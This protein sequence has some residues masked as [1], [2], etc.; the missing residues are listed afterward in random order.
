MIGTVDVLLHLGAFTPKEGHQ[1]NAIKECNSNIIF[2]ENL[3]ALPF[4][5]LKKVI[6]VST[7]DVYESADLI[8]EATPT[9][10]TSLYGWSKL[11]CEQ[12]TSIFATD[13]FIT[14][15]ILRIG[16]VYGPGEEGYSKFLPKTIKNILISDTVELWGDGSEIHSF[17]YIDDVIEATLQSINLVDNVGP[18]NVV[19]GVPITISNLLERLILISGKSIKIYKKEFNGLKRNYI[20]DN[21][22][23]KKYLLSKE[24]DLNQGL[25]N[26]YK[27][28]EKLI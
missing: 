27:Y 25:K 21:S 24:T 2:T 15:Q 16:H 23:L 13:H 22:K 14:C 6:Y 9:L 1:A 18:I 3:L 7:L 10:P 8:T 28:M 20:F 19:G 4:K 11:Y 26:E 5:N 17:I 12:L